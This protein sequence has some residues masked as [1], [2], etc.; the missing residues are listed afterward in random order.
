MELQRAVKD[1]NQATL[2]YVTAYLGAHEAITQLPRLQTFGQSNRMTE[3]QMH[4]A[5]NLLPQPGD[6]G[7]APQKMAKLQGMIDPLRRQIP[8]MPGADLMPSWL[9]RGQQQKTPTASGGSNL[10]N[11]VSG[12][13]S[14]TD[15]VNRLQANR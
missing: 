2:D 8:R 9:E 3:N 4:A 1:A 5:V 7:M 6:A 14:A 11:A 10:G 15:I 13:N 12:G